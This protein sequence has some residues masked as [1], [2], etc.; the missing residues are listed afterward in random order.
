M[1]LQHVLLDKLPVEYSYCW[2]CNVQHGLYTVLYN[3]VS[4]YL[5]LSGSVYNIETRLLGIINAIVVLSTTLRL[6]SSPSELHPQPRECPGHPRLACNEIIVPFA[7]ASSVV[8]F[9]SSCFC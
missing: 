1:V 2:M 3:L 6:I 8:F 7:L 5:Y 9:A 4:L